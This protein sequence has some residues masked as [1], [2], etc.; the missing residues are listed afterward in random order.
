LV[1]PHWSFRPYGPAASSA[2]AC[3]SAISRRA[4][5]TSIADGSKANHLTYL[6]DA[7]IGKGVNVVPAIT[8]NYLRE[9]V[10]DHDRGRRVH[11]LRQHAGGAGATARTRPRARRTITKEVPGEPAGAREADDTSG[12]EAAGETKVVSRVR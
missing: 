10:H 5:K 8:R 2:L 4:K 3:T 1:L 6:G 7:I 12:L 9:Q 11:R